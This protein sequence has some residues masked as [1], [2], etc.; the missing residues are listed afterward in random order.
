[1]RNSAEERY[2]ENKKL[3]EDVENYKKFYGEDNIIL[4]PLILLEEVEINLL[5]DPLGVLDYNT[6]EAWGVNPSL[7]ICIKCVR[8]RSPPFEKSSRYVSKSSEFFH[9][10]RSLRKRTT[11]FQFQTRYMSIRTS[12]RH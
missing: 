9:C 6:A 2:L 4:K 10:E 8:S 3:I 12:R 1:L 7:P 5:M 11:E